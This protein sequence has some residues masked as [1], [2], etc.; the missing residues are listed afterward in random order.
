M[1][2]STITPCL[3]TAGHLISGIEVDI[4]IS[5]KYNRRMHPLAKYEKTLLSII[6]MDLQLHFFWSFSL[7]ILALFWKPFIAAGIGI[8]IVKECFDVYA[9]KGWSWGDFIWGVAGFLAGILFLGSV[10]FF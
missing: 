10:D 6:R 7:T 5:H 2:L 1:V 8:T 4:T 3:Y 9:R